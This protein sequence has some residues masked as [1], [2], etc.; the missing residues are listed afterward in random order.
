[1]WR[2]RDVDEEVSRRA[3][4]GIVGGLALSA[5]GLAVPAHRQAVLE[6]LHIK[7]LG[8]EFVKKDHEDSHGTI[9]A[10][11]LRL[12]NETGER[13][14]PLVSTWDQRRHTRHNWQ[15]EEGPVPLATGET[16]EY[17]VVAPDE[18]A[19]MHA[20]VPAQIT[21]YQ[22]GEQ[23]WKSVGVTTPVRSEEESA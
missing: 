14:D 22:R 3:T 13:L 4:L 5:A 23:R 6:D 7:V 18:T 12:A 19:R 10:V 1:V 21:V 2:P 11:Q 17:R 9:G 15:L 16:G 8:F 20:G